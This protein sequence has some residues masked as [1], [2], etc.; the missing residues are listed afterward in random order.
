MAKIASAILLSFLCAGSAPAQRA[1]PLQLQQTIPLPGVKGSFDHFAID[2]ATDTLFAAAKDNHT[3]EAVNL[4]T[5]NVIQSI[6]GLEKPH[7][8]AWIAATHRLYVADGKLAQLQVYQG[9]PFKTSGTLKLSDDADDM[10]YDEQNGTLYVG[11]GG[12]N[13]ANLGRIAVIDTKD[14]TLAADLP[15]AAHPEA[16]DLDRQGQRVFANIA[17]AA[18]VIVVDTKTNAIEDTWKL[19]GASDNTP[20]AYDA[21]D[22]ILFIACRKPPV[23]IALDGNTGK[24]IG[25]IA[26]N[27]GADDLFYD[28]NLHRIYVI[29][30]AG[31]IDVYSMGVNQH[32]VSLGTVPT[33]KGA[34]TGLLVPS[35]HRLYVGIPGTSGNWAQ[36]RVYATNSGDRK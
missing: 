10:V 24:E 1:L 28:A 26:S 18:Q 23:L 5:G 15:M 29:T 20:M 2:L 9:S 4:K 19:K 27:A 30:G 35:Q 33:E 32:L 22:Q 36:I 21:H 34:K 3:V 12:S 25:R 8:L 16:L 13:A 11:H 6:A 17:D 31:D 14:F 7:G